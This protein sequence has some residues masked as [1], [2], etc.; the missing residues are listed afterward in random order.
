[1]PNQIFQFLFIDKD[2]TLCFVL[3]FIYLLREIDMV[4]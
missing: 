3:L 4:I 1:M 2:K